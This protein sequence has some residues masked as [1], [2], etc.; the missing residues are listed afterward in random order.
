MADCG[1]DVVDYRDVD[2]VYGT[3]REAEELISQARDLGIR[4]IVDIVPNHLSDQ[5]RPSR[6]RGRSQPLRP[7][8]LDVPPQPLGHITQHRIRRLGVRP[9][10][11]SAMGQEQ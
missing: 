11:P 2:P 6:G 1:Y 9:C 4:T 3:L 8:I 5:H 7:A 10:H